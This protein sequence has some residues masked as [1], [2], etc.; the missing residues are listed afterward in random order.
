MESG[1]ARY[2]TLDCFSYFQQFPEQSL[3]GMIIPAFGNQNRG[4]ER[5]FAKIQSKP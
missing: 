4:E 5:Y 2:S 1:D 3:R